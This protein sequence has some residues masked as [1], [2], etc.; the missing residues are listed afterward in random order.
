MDLVLERAQVEPQPLHP[1]KGSTIFLCPKRILG[2]AHR[3]GISPD[4]ASDEV[5]HHGLAHALLETG[6]TPYHLP[7]GRLMG[8][9]LATWVAYRRF[10]GPETLQVQRLIRQLSLEDQGYVALEVGVGPETLRYQDW[11]WWIPPDA[12]HWWMYGVRRGF[13]AHAFTRGIPSFWMQARREAKRHGMEVGFWSK[14]AENIIQK[15]L[16]LSSSR[17]G[18]GRMMLSVRRR[19]NI[20]YVSYEKG[21]LLSTIGIGSRD[22][23]VG[24]ARGTVSRRWGHRVYHHAVRSRLKGYRPA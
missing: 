18:G 23:L 22:E 3:L 14:K 20:L 8:E 16:E 13:L 5:Y 19:G 21:R 6:P 10:R 7:W 4:P 11:G 24:R 9:S 17:L 12:W 1:D 2:A 15:V